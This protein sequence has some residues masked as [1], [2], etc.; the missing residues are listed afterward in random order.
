MWEFQPCQ[1]GP[2]T[3]VPPKRTWELPHGTP[4]HKQFGHVGTPSAVLPSVTLVDGDVQVLQ[5]LF[6][7]PGYFMSL[8]QAAVSQ[9]IFWFRFQGS[10]LCSKLSD[11]V[12]R[13]EQKDIWIP[14]GYDVLLFWKSEISWL[15]SP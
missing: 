9:H 13:N 14:S 12:P 1:I 7:R 11:S 10:D 5:A 6:S 3:E 4:G 8:G 15:H 2:L